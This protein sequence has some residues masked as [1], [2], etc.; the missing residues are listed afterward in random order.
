MDLDL[1]S[2]AYAPCALLLVD[3]EIAPLSGSRKGFSVFGVRVPA[4][5]TAQH[6]EALEEAMK[7]EPSFLAQVEAAVGRVQRPGSETLFRWERGGR[8]YEVKLSALGRGENRPFAVVFNDVTEHIRLEEIRDSTRRYLED[9]LNNIR[10]GVAVLS[11]ELRITNLNRAQEG[12]LRRLGARL[13]WVD[14][15]G[16]PI[17]ELTPQDPAALWEEITAQVLERGEPYRDPRR[18]YTTP[19]GDLILSV[20]ITPL[21]DV[22]G[23]M[24][25]AIQ[26]SEDVTERMRLEEEL[27]QAEIVAERLEAVR[28][29]A[30]TV[31]HEVNNPLTTILATAQMLLLVEKDLSKPAQERLRQIEY[32]AKR[33]AEVAKRLRSVEEVRTKEYISQGPKMLD[34][35]ELGS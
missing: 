14:A 25:G 29:T 27:R 10:L 15:I 22:R 5:P 26:I 4:N 11:R 19:E 24:I 31:N 8:A 30:I 2:L 1:K 12:F 18:V 7:A 16:M 23:E 32:N 28:E 35:G 6:L 17:S 3:R 13:S 34:I 9:I 20:E 21:R 33:I